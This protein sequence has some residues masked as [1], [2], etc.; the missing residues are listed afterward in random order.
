MIATNLFIP[1]TL[2][3]ISFSKWTIRRN[4][5][6][7]LKKLSSIIPNFSINFLTNI[8]NLA[9]YNFKWVTLYGLTL[10]KSSLPATW[11][12]WILLTKHGFS[13]NSALANKYSWVNIYF[14]W[15][16]DFFVNLP[17]YSYNKARFYI[18][19]PPLT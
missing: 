14:T 3:L 7:F 18:H 19:N 6:V 11:S 5:L 4:S 13:I 12:N 8:I 2:L 10:L 17:T 15:L 1:T 9:L 16:S